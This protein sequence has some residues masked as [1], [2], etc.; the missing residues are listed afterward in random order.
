MRFKGARASV[1][2]LEEMMAENK[3]FDTPIRGFDGVTFDDITF[4][5]P[6]G[7]QLLVD[8]FYFGFPHP[9]NEIPRQLQE[10]LPLLYDTKLWR[11]P[12]S[13]AV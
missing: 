8:T 6:N 13:E 9:R 2:R 3:T 7:K 11:S 4:G 12:S 10:D 1:D 5:Y